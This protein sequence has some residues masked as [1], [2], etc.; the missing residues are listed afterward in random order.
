MPFYTSDQDPEQK[1]VIDA[2]VVVPNDSHVID[3]L[4]GEQESKGSR[5]LRLCFLASTKEHWT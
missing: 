5:P 4:V 3:V 2:M 1:S